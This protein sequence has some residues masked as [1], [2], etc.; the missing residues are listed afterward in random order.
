ME[1]VPNKYASIVRTICYILIPIF[2][3][4]IAQSLIT[5]YYFEGQKQKKMV[6]GFYET[7][8]LTNSISGMLETS[9]ENVCDVDCEEAKEGE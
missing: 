8:Q 9:C 2:I 6:Y 5:L 4:S 3:L 7:E 1:K